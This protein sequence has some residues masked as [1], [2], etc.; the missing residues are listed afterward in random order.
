ME[1]AFLAQ[2]QQTDKDINTQGMTEEELEAI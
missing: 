2:K 1:V